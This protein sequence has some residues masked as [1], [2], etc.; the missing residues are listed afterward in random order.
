[1]PEEHNRVVSDHLSDLL[2]CP[3]DNA[4]ENLAREGIVRGVHQVGDVMYDSV[5][6]NA[7]LAKQRSDILARMRLKPG[8]YELATV[9]RAENY[10]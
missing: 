7:E 2:F 4:V 3:T 9:H 1:M 10:G 8:E 6:Y 5:L